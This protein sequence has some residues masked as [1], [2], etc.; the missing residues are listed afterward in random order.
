MNLETAGNVARRQARWT[1]FA[2]VG[3]FLVQRFAVPGLPISMTVPLLLL[4]AGLAVSRGVVEVDLTRTVWWLGASGVTA[5]LM[6]PQVAL[7]TFPLISVNSWLL[8]TI[9]WL[10]MMFRFTD[11]SP[12]AHQVTLRAV[13]SAGGWISGLS[14]LFILVQLAGIS[15]RDL[16]AEFVPSS[17]Q[18]QGFVISYPIAYGSP[19]YK[20]NAWLALEPS[21]LSFMLGVALVSALASRRHPVLVLWLATGLLCTTAGS[22][23]AVVGVYLIVALLSGQGR[24]LVR[25]VVLAVPAA[26]LAALTAL[27]DSILDRVGEAGD[28]RSSTGLRVFEPY[29]HLVPQW[30]ADPARLFVG[31][32]PGSSQRVVDDLGV[33]G[34]LVPTPAKML[35]DYGLLGGLLMLAMVLAAYL[36]SPAPGFAFALAFSMLTLQGAAQPLVA[37]TLLCITLFAPMQP[38]GAP[39]DELVSSRT[40]VLTPRLQ[41]SVP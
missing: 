7:L 16:F 5:L 8:W 34:L 35:Y 29:V 31:G 40:R 12:K 37:M 4:W 2:F 20:S 33:L 41:A 3:V 10:P 11:R 17:L 39:G 27:G 28:T 25:Y 15:Y 21:F 22:G 36:G 14:V 19:I 1:A 13:S 38:A 6:V 23:I 26:A 18:L 32:G 30:L 24:H 9:T